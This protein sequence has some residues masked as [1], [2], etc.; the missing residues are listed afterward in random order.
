MQSLRHYIR[1]VE[2]KDQKLVQEK[3]PFDRK[4]LEPVMSKATLDY[5]Y[6]KLAGGYVERFN[7]GE[8]D[9]D[10]NYGGAT[11]HNLFFPQLQPP[12][13]GNRPHGSSLELIERK[14]TSFEKFKQEVTQVAMAIQ[15]SGW[16]YLAKDGK[17]KTIVNHEI[18]NDIVLLIDWWEHSWALD[19]QADKKRYLSNIWKIIDWRYINGVLGQSN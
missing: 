8:G 18:R 4:A 6:G 16:V 2:S 12:K 13:A 11:L 1:L 9:S 7:K 15:G 19:Y 10:F 3:L 17:I 14:Y 5:H